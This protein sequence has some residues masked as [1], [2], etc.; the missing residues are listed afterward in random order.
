MANM[1]YAVPSGLVFPL[2][3]RP[4]ESYKESPRSYGSNRANGRKHAGCDLYAATGTAVL[5]MAQGT[6]IREVYDFYCSTYA[7]EIDHGTFVARYGEILRTP[8]SQFK[9]GD[10]VRPGQM[11]GAVGQLDCYHISMLHMEIYAGGFD[12]ALTTNQGS[13]RRRAD[14]VDASPYLDAAKVGL[15]QN[16]D[17]TVKLSR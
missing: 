6:V 16:A 13:F 17:G 7:L 5:A 3:F 9:V 10:E 8:A 15:A 12:G 2:P 11:I 14:L 1:T 4:T